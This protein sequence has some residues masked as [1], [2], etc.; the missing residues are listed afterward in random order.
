MARRVTNSSPPVQM[1][2]LQPDALPRP[3][4][5]AMC[6]R[7]T[8]I[9]TSMSVAPSVT[10]DCAV[11]LWVNFEPVDRRSI[12]LQ[13][14]KTNFSSGGSSS[15][16]SSTKTS[17]DGSKQ[18]AEGDPSTTT[19]K[20]RT[21]PV[22]TMGARAP[23]RCPACEC[24]VTSF[25]EMHLTD[26]NRDG[27]YDIT[28]ALCT[29]RFHVS[30]PNLKYRM[31][32]EAQSAED[33]DVDL[34]P[35]YEC[36]DYEVDKLHDD[37]P[38]KYTDTGVGGADSANYC[39]PAPVCLVVDRSLLGSVGEW[40]LQYVATEEVEQLHAE[41]GGNGVGT[42]TAWALNPADYMVESK[43]QRDHLQLVQQEQQAQELIDCAKQGREATKPRRGSVFSDNSF[44]TTSEN[45]GG[46]TTVP[47]SDLEV[48]SNF[49]PVKTVDLLSCSASSA[50]SA[51]SSRSAAEMNASRVLFPGAESDENK[52]QDRNGVVDGSRNYKTLH[53]C[54]NSTEDGTAQTGRR[55]SVVKNEL[56]SKNSSGDD[57]SLLFE[58]LRIVL[59]VYD[60]ESVYFLKRSERDEF[61]LAVC[62]HTDA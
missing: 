7:D 62:P 53:N 6:V 33:E 10:N 12:L 58:N 20:H 29:E 34:L 37:D 32:F 60:S 49:S 40:L 28:C 14:G 36:V 21:A 9:T 26:N 41:R 31:I 5:N 13:Q 56:P 3:T 45:E 50:S 8:V 39:E 46:S 44:S 1:Y 25:F 11:P 27:E 48:S 18:T 59:V 52:T 30:D 22:V 42:T 23:L 15:S 43:E 57:E 47:S 55:D 19:A 16:S 35:P 61:G 17:R 2:R 54:S 51:S 38:V 24:F 4:N